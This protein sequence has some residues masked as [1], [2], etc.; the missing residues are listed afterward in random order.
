M[1]GIYLTAPR[2]TP[3]PRPVGGKR[4]HQLGRYTLLPPS[5]A[6]LAW[7]REQSTLADVALKPRIPHALRAGAFTLDEARAAGVTATA[8]RGKSWLRLERG[9]YCWREVV[10]EPWRLLCALQRLQPDVVFAGR[11]AAWLHGI[12]I[13]PA[14]PIEVI[15]TRSS[16]MRSRLGVLVGRSVVA[17]DEV[18]IVRTLRATSPRR[19]LSDLCVRLAGVDALVVLD[20]ALRKGLGR[21]DGPAR[22]TR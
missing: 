22:R 5:Q 3:Q 15:V 10:A 14:H 2:I 17:T 12:D 16:G 6:E 11:T 4:V 19:T 1:C 13:D 8:L 18:V 21:M 9:I 20:A 7:D